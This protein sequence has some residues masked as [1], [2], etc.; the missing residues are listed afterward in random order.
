MIR[1][2]RVYEEKSDRDGAR[3]LVDRL[4]PRGL[5]KEEVGAVL[6]LKEIA[7]SEELRRQFGHDPKKWEFFRQRYLEELEENR[8][9]LQKIIDEAAR[10]DVVLLYGA[11]DS[12]HNNAVVLKEY[13]DRW[14]TR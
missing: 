5:K 13:V 11:K 1:I 3:I 7:P 4:W 8:E 14:F 2:R 12:E 10:G 6:W 9:A